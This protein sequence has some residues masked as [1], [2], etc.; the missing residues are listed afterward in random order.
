MERIE[1]NEEPPEDSWALRSGELTQG[2]SRAMTAMTLPTRE[3]M[4]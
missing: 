3:T 2:I 4:A 1:K